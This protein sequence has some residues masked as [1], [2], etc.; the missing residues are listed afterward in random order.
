V[1][2]NKDGTYTATFALR[3]SGDFLVDVVRHEI[4]DKMRLPIFGSP[5]PIACFPAGAHGPKCE[6]EGTPSLHPRVRVRVR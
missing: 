2:D 3:R 5:Y 4:S 6:A 1:R